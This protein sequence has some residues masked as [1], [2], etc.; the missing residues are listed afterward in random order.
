MGTSAAHFIIHNLL[1][2]P[3]LLIIPIQTRPN[4]HCPSSGA[5]PTILLPL[6]RSYHLHDSKAAHLLLMKETPIRCDKPRAGT[7]ISHLTSSHTYLLWPLRH[8][9]L[10]IL[11]QPSVHAQCPSR[12][13][14]PSNLCLARPQLTVDSS[15]A[16][17]LRKLLFRKQFE[18]NLQ[19]KWVHSIF[20]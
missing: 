12:R 13:R 17:K 19:Y 6:N 11:P 8:Q 2:F 10:L 9:R 7:A 1:H 15:V 16:H 18:M 3:N 14:S 5:Y 20:Q 4:T